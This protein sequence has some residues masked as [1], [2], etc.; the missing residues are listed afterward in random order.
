M[1]SLEKKLG[2]PNSLPSLTWYHFLA[3]PF[4]TM[5]VDMPGFHVQRTRPDFHH[6]S[7][8]QCTAWRTGNSHSSEMRAVVETW[9]FLGLEAG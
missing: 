1:D 8:M 4:V 5:L 2:S 7:E 3:C 6:V 9:T